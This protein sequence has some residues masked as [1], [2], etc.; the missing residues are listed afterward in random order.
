MVPGVSE[1]EGLK[2]S[3][4]LAAEQAALDALTAAYSD[5]LAAEAAY[6]KP[7]QVCVAHVCVCVCV[8]GQGLRGKQHA[9]LVMATACVA[10]ARGVTDCVCLPACAMHDG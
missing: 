1:L 7:A 8:E 4:V 5:L 9:W 3:M 10:V 6:R 2:P